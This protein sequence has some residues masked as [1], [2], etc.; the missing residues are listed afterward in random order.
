MKKTLILASASPQRRRI[1]KRLG[2]PFRIIPSHVSER[3]TEKDPRRMVV[4]LARRK[5]LAIARL[6]PEALVLGADTIVVCGGKI[7]GKPRDSAHALRIL[8]LQ[9]G[10]WQRVYTGVA[11][12]SGGGRRVVC[13]AAMSRVLCRRLPDAQLRVYAGKHMDKAGG[14]SVSD[15]RDPFVARV[16]GDFDN[17][18]GLP[19][20]AVKRV[21]RRALI[22]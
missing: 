12:A 16:E 14:Y 4:L 22:W 15:R 19:L 8:K 13:E 1:L 6:H 11:A 10:R 5:A 17:V 9:N 18:V 3:T 21:L 20:K 2:R 7:L